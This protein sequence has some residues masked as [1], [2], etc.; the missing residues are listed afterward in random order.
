VDLIIESLQVTEPLAYQVEHL[1][2]TSWLL[3]AAVVETLTLEAAVEL[4]VY[5]I[6]QLNLFHPQ[7]T[8]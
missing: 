4:V 7:I 6:P 2:A 5:F 8:M 3:L 1:R